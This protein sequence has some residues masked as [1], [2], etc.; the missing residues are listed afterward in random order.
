[1]AGG[2][3]LCECAADQSMARAGLAVESLAQHRRGARISDDEC[4]APTAL[5]I[6]ER[7]PRELRSIQKVHG[8]Q[9][10]GATIHQRDVDLRLPAQDQILASGLGHPVRRTMTTDRRCGEMSRRFWSSRLTADNLS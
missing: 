2:E 9:R 5:D 4:R 8:R 3:H 1:M 6:G 7:G 10:E